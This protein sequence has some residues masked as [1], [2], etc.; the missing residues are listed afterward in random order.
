MLLF[1]GAA[2]SYVEEPTHDPTH[3]AKFS[4]ETGADVY[5]IGGKGAKGFAC[6]LETV[7]RQFACRRVLVFHRAIRSISITQHVLQAIKSITD[8]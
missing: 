8:C 5:L 7:A 6:C 1:A 2:L 4:R 3:M